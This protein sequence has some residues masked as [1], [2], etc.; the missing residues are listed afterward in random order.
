M[1]GG[2]SEAIVRLSVG[3]TA[4]FVSPEGLILTNHHCGYEAL[5]ASSTSQNN[6]AENGFKADS[7][8]QELPA[9]GYS[10]D[11]TLKQ[12]DITS[13]VLNGINV[14]DAEAL[15]K[16]L[17]ELENEEKTKVGEGIRVQIQ[18]LNNGLFYYLFHYQTI[19]D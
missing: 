5:V 1:S 15:N 6:R 7:R 8:A 16:R 3:C 9:P 19:K 11:I 14:N 10:L 12:E 17:A 2:L 4:E 13:K 18:A